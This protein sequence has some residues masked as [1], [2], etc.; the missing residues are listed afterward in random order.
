M[1]GPWMCNTH[2]S[3]IYTHTNVFPRVGGRKKKTFQRGID[4]TDA[5]AVASIQERK[6]GGR[7]LYSH[8]RGAAAC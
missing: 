3:N 2:A 6:R 4:M 1:M 7:Q 8:T 5:G